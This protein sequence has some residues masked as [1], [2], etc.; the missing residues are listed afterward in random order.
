MSE[1]EQRSHDGVV[2][3]SFWIP[4]AVACLTLFFYQGLRDIL[5]GRGPVIESIMPLLKMLLIAP[6]GAVVLTFLW[7]SSASILI[8]SIVTI[9]GRLLLFSDDVQH[10]FT[11]EHL[12]FS[13]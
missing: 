9:A 2:G 12:I 8:G 10:Y 1:N 13:G 5:I 3:G 6:A 7:R 11:A 4:I